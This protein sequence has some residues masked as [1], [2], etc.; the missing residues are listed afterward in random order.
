MDDL[1]GDLDT[2]IARFQDEL[3]P[4][5]DTDLDRKPRDGGWSAREAICHL[6]T[7]V[8]LYLEQ[9]EA[10]LE[11]KQGNGRARAKAPG[12]G[13]VGGMLL[14]ALRNPGKR[15]DAP[16]VFR[17]PPQAAGVSVQD[18]IATHKR[19]RMVA[20]T[21]GRR[22]LERLRVASPLSPLLR[23]PARAAIEVQIVHGA[24]HLAQA[25]A[26]AHATVD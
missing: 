15:Y 2:L 10:V 12:P 7:S 24:R 16:R 17:P 13:L 4:L 26:A 9:L 14:R 23:M 19:L 5:T 20:E 18:L 22:N 6:E 8:R 25:L 21:L 11:R 3:H 1:I